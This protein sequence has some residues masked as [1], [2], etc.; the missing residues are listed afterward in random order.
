MASRWQLFFWERSALSRGSEAGCCL[1]G[2]GLSTLSRRTDGGRPAHGQSGLGWSGGL[3]VGAIWR[4]GFGLQAK[5]LAG[6]SIGAGW[7]GAM[8]AGGKRGSESGMASCT[9]LHCT[10]LH[11]TALYCTVLYWYCQQ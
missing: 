1:L 8:P 6:F 10:V 9:A 2:F 11:C 7:R 5:L 3:G 4:V